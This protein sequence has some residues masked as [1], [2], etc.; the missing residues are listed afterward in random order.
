MPDNVIVP[1]S[2]QESLDALK[3]ITL[4]DGEVWSAR[5]LMP[6]AG[7]ERWERF[8]DAITR[9]IASVNASGLDASE[10]FRGAAKSSPMPNGGTREIEDVQLTR[11]GCYILLQNADARKPEVARAQQ[12]FAIQTRKQELSQPA[13]DPT[14]IE[15][16]QLILAA[17]QTALAKVKELE[18]LAEREMTFRQAKGLCTI[19]DVANDFR[20]HC[21]ERFPDVKVLNQAV[22]DHAGRIG[23]IIRGN[24]VRHNQPTAEAIKAGWVRPHRKV[25]E[26]NS[27]WKEEKKSARLTPKGQARLWDALCAWVGQNGSLA[28][29]SVAS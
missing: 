22:F 21:A 15:G 12:Y 13:F 6:Y 2:I 10:H 20:A 28:I 27:G 5:D 1:R 18:P 24:T 3:I 9:A 29:E 4:T 23:L 11:Y 26:H 16:V 14:S 17:A 7:Y 8:S 25:V 19:S